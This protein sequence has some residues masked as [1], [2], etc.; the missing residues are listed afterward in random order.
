[1]GYQAQ[2]TPANG[3]GGVELMLRRSGRLTV[4]QCKAHAKK[5]PIGVAR[6]L[7]ASMADFKADEAIIAC[8]EGVTGLVM[9]Y[10]RDKSM[11]VITSTQI[12]DMQ[13][14]LD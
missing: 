2:L 14:N 7:A 3:D 9:V 10:V 4:V 11:N 8:F 1:M 6:E 13:R 5:L 12:V